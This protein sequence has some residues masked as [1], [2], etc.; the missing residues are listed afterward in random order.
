MRLP[1]MTIQKQ[2]VAIAIL[3]IGI[4]AGGIVG[5]DVCRRWVNCRNYADYCA[6]LAIK[7]PEDKTEF[8]ATSRKYRR[9]LWFPWRFYALGDVIGTLK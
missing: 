6:S 1:R 4:V 7:Y 2:M 9:A 8:E 3:A 5:P